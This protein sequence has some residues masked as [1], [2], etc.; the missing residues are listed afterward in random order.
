ML[1]FFSGLQRVC[2]LVFFSVA[3]L[4]T[5]SYAADLESPRFLIKRMVAATSALNY[6]GVFVYQ[7]GGQIDSM[8]ILHRLDGDTEVER[9]VSLSGPPREVIRKGDQVQCFFPEGREVMVEKIVPKDFFTFG[10]DASVDEIAEHY[11][12]RLAGPAR[13]AGRDGSVI[14]IVPIDSDRYAYQLV[15]DKGVRF[16]AQI[17]DLRA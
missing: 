2:A 10:L 5:R 13:I 7:R 1:I 8:R 17:G 11:Q 3:L 14:S 12:L 15:V 6:R 9:L 16:A 4:A